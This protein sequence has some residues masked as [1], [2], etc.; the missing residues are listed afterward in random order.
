MIHFSRQN[1][2]VENIC[3]QVRE[4]ART[5]S[6]PCTWCKE[7]HGVPN[8][9]KNVQ[10]AKHHLRGFFNE[11]YQNPRKDHPWSSLEDFWWI[12]INAGISLLVSLLPFFSHSQINEHINGEINTNNLKVKQH[13]DSFQNKHYYWW[14]YFSEIWVKV[15]FFS[16]NCEIAYKCFL[17]SLWDPLE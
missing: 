17:L 10:S 5:R 3:R 12:Y 8:L 2:D 14:E 16:F 11:D 1:Q 9:I 15:F 4:W 6:Y 13:S 7:K